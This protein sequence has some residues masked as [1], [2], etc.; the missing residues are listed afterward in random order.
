[1]TLSRASLIRA[2]ELSVLI[3]QFASAQHTRNAAPPAPNSSPAAATVNIGSNAGPPGSV[4][5]LPIYVNPPK[6]VGMGK[7]TIQVSFPASSLRFEKLERGPVFKSVELHSEVASA[8]DAKGIA[9]TMLTI[10]VGITNV[11]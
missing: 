1:M 8:K 3:V 10:T 11:E 5:V 9:T 2:I 6:G 7:L 4:V